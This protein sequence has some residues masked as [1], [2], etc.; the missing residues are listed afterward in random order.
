MSPLDS[1]KDDRYRPADTYPTWVPDYPDS[2][3][4]SLVDKNVL[5]QWLAQHLPAADNVDALVIFTDTRP[6][7]KV[8]A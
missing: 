1:S 6:L 5:T 4:T 7:D 8:G 2:H 3:L